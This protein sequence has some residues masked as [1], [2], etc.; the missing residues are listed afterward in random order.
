MSALGADMKLSESISIFA[1]L[2]AIVQSWAP[3]KNDK[4]FDRSGSYEE[5]TIHYNGTYKVYS[6][7]S[8]YYQPQI[9]FPSAALVFLAE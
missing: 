8:Q 1:E 3:E 4:T 9:F 5:Y 7:Y 2:D 6:N